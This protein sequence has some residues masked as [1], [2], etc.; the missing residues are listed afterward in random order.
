MSTLVTYITRSR[1]KQGLMHGGSGKPYCL[2]LARH[3]R[4][5]LAGR[6]R[7]ANQTDSGVYGPEC[8]AA[9][10]EVGEDGEGEPV[11]AGGG[12]SARVG[13]SRLRGAQGHLAGEIAGVRRGAG[14]RGALL[15]VRPGKPQAS[16]VRASRRTQLH[17][18]H[19]PVRV[20][21]Q[22]KQEKERLAADFKRVNSENEK[23]T[24]EGNARRLN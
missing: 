12:A 11:G 10:R 18:R 13:E 8:A 4:P 19:R 9:G 6:N 2:G 5:P 21:A 3:Q 16:I 1:N 20:C 23:L 24:I 14:E 7:G 15:A 17:Q 22:E